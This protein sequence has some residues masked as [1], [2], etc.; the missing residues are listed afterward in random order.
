MEYITASEQPSPKKNPKNP[1]MA[2]IF[3]ASMR[4]SLAAE[5]GMRLPMMRGLAYLFA[6][7]K[8]IQTVS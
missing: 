7:A 4:A 6:T 5:A 1:Q 2:A 3:K 8:L